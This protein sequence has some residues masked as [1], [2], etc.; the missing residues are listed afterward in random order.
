[1]EQ[2]CVYIVKED[3]EILRVFSDTD[4][5][6]EF[7]IEKGM[8]YEQNFL[9]SSWKVEDKI[10]ATRYEI[11]RSTYYLGIFYYRC[12]DKVFEIED[13]VVY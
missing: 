9:T 6:H 1:M 2:T 7:M 13:R 5:A 10:T 12:V 11:S 4:S 8:E 3:K